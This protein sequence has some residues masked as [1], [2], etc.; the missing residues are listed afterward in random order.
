M[1]DPYDLLA[2]VA[3]RPEVWPNHSAERE[4]LMAIDANHPYVP[5]IREAFQGCGEDGRADGLST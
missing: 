4:A 2:V 1:S 3:M 5:A